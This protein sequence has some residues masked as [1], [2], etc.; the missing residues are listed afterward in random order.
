MY[1]FSRILSLAITQM[2]KWANDYTAIGIVLVVATF[3][4]L[5]LDGLISYV[6]ENNLSV[7]VYQLP[8][9]F[10]YRYSRLLLTL[11]II[12]IFSKI[13]EVEGIDLLILIR[14]KRR[15][16][17]LGQILYIFFSSIFYVILLHGLIV[18]YLLPS[19]EWNLD[20]G[21]VMG[22]L[23][24][25]GIPSGY[26]IHQIFPL[27]IYDYFTPSQAIFYHS[28]LLFLVSALLGMVMLISKLAFKTNK[29]GIVVASVI[30]MLDI[31]IKDKML[32]RWFSPITWLDLSIIKVAELTP[33]PSIGYV[34]GFLSI[35]IILLSSV[36]LIL[37]HYR[38][39]V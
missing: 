31:A 36:A 26:E 12:L 1:G 9:L 22:N 37:A 16:W 14:T 11:P 24:R 27:K 4:H 34:I 5:M 25:Q 15:Y 7:T 39:Q 29:V 17:C 10:S 23:F 30:I 33:T 20:W 21:T 18:L 13:A 3:V 2:K 19:I 8:F 35:G 32:I 28:L 6:S 38:E